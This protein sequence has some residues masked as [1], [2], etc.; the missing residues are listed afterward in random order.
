MRLILFNF[1]RIR[2]FISKLSSLDTQEIEK[3]TN[4]TGILILLFLENRMLSEKNLSN[5]IDVQNFLSKDQLKR[6]KL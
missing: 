4:S 6:K 1:Q 2:D 5:R 3:L